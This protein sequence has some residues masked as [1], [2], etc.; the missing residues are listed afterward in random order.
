MKTFLSALLAL[1]LV[2]AELIFGSGCSPAG[3]ESTPGQLSFY[4]DSPE[5]WEMFEAA[6]DRIEA[7]SGTR[8]YTAL[9]GT[10]ITVG[11]QPEGVTSC[12]DTTVVYI[13]TE[14]KSITI[15]LYSDVDGCFESISDTLVHEMIHAVR[16][17]A[18]MD[19]GVPDHGHS[20]A[21]IFRAKAGD[22]RF[23]ETTLNA[24][25]EAVDCI[26]YNPEN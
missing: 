26:N 3:S 17:R 10:P 9:A 4:P 19:L 21:G 8:P 12:A 18:G 6:A 15:A 20:V 1:G 13:G 14:V 16:A 22:E 7:A 23:E 11:P 25:C 5:A 24:F 2:G